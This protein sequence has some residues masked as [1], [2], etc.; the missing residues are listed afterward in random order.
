MG[1]VYQLKGGEAL[2]LEIKAGIWL[3]PLMEKRVGGR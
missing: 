3:I 1:N 2:R